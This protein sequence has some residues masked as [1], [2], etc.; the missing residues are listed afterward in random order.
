MRVLI[1]GVAGSTGRLLAERLLADPGI[2][3]VIGL[4]ARACHPPVPGMIFVRADLRQPE[5]TG[6]LREVDIVIHL[7]GMG[8][9]L[10]W[11]QRAGEEGR[12]EGTR[13]LVQALRVARVPR[14]IAINSAA[15]YGPQPPGEVA[16]TAPAHGYHYGAYARA[17]AQIEDMLA[18]MLPAIPETAV[19]R[20][21]TAWPS[22]STHQALVRHFAR[23]PVLACGLEDRCLHVVHEGDL[24]DAT[25]FVLWHD[26]I[27]I[28][29]VAA[30]T[31]LTF[32]E[33]AA[34]VGK[35][36]ACVPLA[37]ITLG[38]WWRWRWRGQ[39]TPPGWVRSLYHSQPLSTAKLRAAG[40]QPQRRPREAISAALEAYQAS[41]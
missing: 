1:T 7:A 9:P 30:S 20:L 29:N 41:L 12:I 13:A 11:R 35:T 2:A 6:L 8:W 36:R 28:Y 17:R 21:R 19:T 39:R 34:L 5:W 4:D 22:G 18:E 14:L 23:N 38:A 16:E 10:P 37:W 27:G 26:L 33:L 3:S 25:R 15:L 40:W 32:G 31:A 24:V